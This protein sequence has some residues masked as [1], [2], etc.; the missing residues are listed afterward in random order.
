MLEDS[1]MRLS[2]IGLLVT[3]GIGLLWTPLVATAQQPVKVWRIGLFHVGLDHVPASLDGVRERLKE[4]GY[5][6]GKNLRLDWRNLPDEA[7]AHA[8]ASEFVRERIDLIGAFENQTIQAAKAATTEIPIVMIHADDP[9]GNGFVHSL[10]HPGGNLTGQAAFAWEGW[11]A[12]KLEL[13]KELVPHLSRVLVLVDPHD[14]LTP[15]LLPEIQRADAPLQ[16][17]ITVREVTTQAEIEQLF[18]TLPPGEVEGVFVASSHLETNF[19]SLTMQLALAH[20]LPMPVP[21][22]QWVIEGGLFYYGIK[23]RTTGWAAA[24]QMDKIMEG[25]KPADIP[26][27][28][29]TQFELVINLKTAQQIGLTIPPNFLARADR[30]IR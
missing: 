9:V 1:T 28:Q 30:V 11:Y 7:A 22:R 15:R 21:L 14:S 27:E 26:V 18:S 13:F 17:A 29:P 5:E 8:T 19:P 6:E 10:A 24:R 20:H 4:L 12:K 3:F 23:H 16:L 2:P 25:A